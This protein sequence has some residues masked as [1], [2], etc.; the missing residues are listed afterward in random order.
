MIDRILQQGLQHQ[1]RH[2]RIGRTL[3]DIPTNA[4]PLAQPQPL[5]LDVL[6]AQRNLRGQRHQFARVLHQGAK[7]LG[8][9]FERLFGTARIAADDAENA[10]Q[11]VE[12]KMRAD[13]RRERHQPGFG[14]GRRMR[15]PRKMPPDCNQCRNRDS[16]RQPARKIGRAEHGR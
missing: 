10:V 13:A 16:Q 15:L 6:A 2:Q 8:Q 11:A 12:Q 5:Q 4:H 1:R 14:E 9:F 3:F 7:Q